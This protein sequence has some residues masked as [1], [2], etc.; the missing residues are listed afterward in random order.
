ML[1]DSSYSF[2]VVI[3]QIRRVD[4]Q[5]AVKSMNHALE[6]KRGT[7]ESMEITTN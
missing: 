1:L 2:I 6:K 5:I 7:I 4:K 3:R